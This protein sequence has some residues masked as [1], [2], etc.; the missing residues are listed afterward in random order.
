MR[1]TSILISAIQILSLA[2]CVET[3]QLDSRDASVES[4]SNEDASN[5]DAS[6]EDMPSE[7]PTD[8]NPSVDGDD[9]DNDKP[10]GPQEPHTYVAP[11]VPGLVA[12]DELCPEYPPEHEAG[13]GLPAGTVC[14]Y[15]GDD[16]T[17]ATQSLYSECRCQASLC[18]DEIDLRWSCYGVSAGRMTCPPTRPEPGTSCFGF[19]GTQCY[20]P[21]MQ[22]C[23]CPTDEGDVNWACEGAPP[24]EEHPTVVPENVI[25][26]DMS[27]DQRQTWCDW[28][29]AVP[30][31]FPSPPELEPDADGYYPTDS[32]SAT[33]D[34]DC[35]VYMPGDF[36]SSACVDNLALSHCQAELSALNDCVLT[37]RTGTPQPTGCGA[38]ITSEGCS[39]TIV[40]R[41]S[42]DSPSELTKHCKLKVR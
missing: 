15:F 21:V 20:Y 39:G 4:A 33:I 32:C 36:P 34:R 25:V 8:V 18:A 3:L 22:E 29:T 30:A 31:G 10:S 38:F 1:T 7:T 14:A 12:N 9:G 23:S 37:L 24:V 6:N 16:P 19:K 13:C 28:L 27:A 2:G 42:G 41:A 40:T 26:A 35:G 17:I 11:E 5:E